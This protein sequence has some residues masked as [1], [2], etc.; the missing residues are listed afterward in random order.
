MSWADKAS[1]ARHREAGDCANWSV[2]WADK[3]SGARPREACDCA[4]RTSRSGLTCLRQH[5][6]TTLPQKCHAKAHQSHIGLLSAKSQETRNVPHSP[7]LGQ[8][9]CRMQ[10]SRKRVAASGQRERVEQGTK[11]AHPKALTSLTD[12][13]CVRVFHGFQHW[14]CRTKR[15]TWLD[16]IG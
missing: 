11:T 8:K 12:G 3:A 15:S 7:E 9:R 13:I 4:N 14:H 10:L 2:Y 5:P 16:L 6:T 1:G